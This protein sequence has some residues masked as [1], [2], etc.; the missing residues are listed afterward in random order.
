MIK[1]LKNQGGQNPIEAAKL[2]CKIYHVHIFI[3]KK[4][5]KF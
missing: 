3:P 5:M 1:K 2:D 4:S